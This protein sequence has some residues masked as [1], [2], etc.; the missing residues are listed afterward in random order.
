MPGSVFSCQ[1]PHCRG[2][3]LSADEAGEAI[4]E[5][6]PARIVRRARPFRQ[7]V[8]MEAIEWRHQRAGRNKDGDVGAQF[9]RE[10]GL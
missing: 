3:A 7:I 2:D 1:R 4:D 6:N 9:A 10:I 5:L 8:G